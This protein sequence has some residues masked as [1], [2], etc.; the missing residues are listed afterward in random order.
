MSVLIV[1]SGSSKTDWRWVQTDGTAM[2]LST[3]GINPTLEDLQA[4]GND[5]ML[6][7]LR[8]WQPEE[9]HFYGAGCSDQQVNAQMTALLGAI[10]P[11]AAVGVYSDLL[12]AARVLFGTGSG[13]ACI[14][15]TGSNS[16][17]YAAGE[18]RTN[19]LSLGY[20]L[21][22]EGGGVYL[23]KHL[24]R[25]YLRGKMPTEIRQH[26]DATLQMDR[27][28]LYERIYRM[29]Y[30]NRFLASVVEQI[31]P[32]KK[33]AYIHALASEAFFTFFEQCI[34]LYPDYK[35]YPVGFVGSIAH[36]FSDVLLSV[37]RAQGMVC[38]RIIHRPIDALVDFHFSDQKIL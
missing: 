9:V 18:V 29:P 2:E 13:I 25:D 15:G 1:E 12:A 28:A 4:L 33:T 26:L 32:F 36:H 14:L 3:R 37:V 6:A 34:A 38:E 21:G 24:L 5:P 19:V 11:K 35:E 17:L 20:L 10:F 22:D 16:C 27:A 8:A 31:A 23:G 7:P 30:P